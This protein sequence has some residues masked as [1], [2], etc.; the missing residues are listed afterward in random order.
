MLK[1]DQF[2]VLSFRSNMIISLKCNILD[3]M[4]ESLIFSESDEL[5]LLLFSIKFEDAQSMIADFSHR[6]F[7]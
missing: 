6:Y 2:L 7:D 5:K 3:S 4:I 1:A